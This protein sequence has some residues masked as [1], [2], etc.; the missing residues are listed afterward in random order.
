M[1]IEFDNDLRERLAAFQK[2]MGLSGDGVAGQKTWELLTDQGTAA[3]PLVET[4]VTGEERAAGTAAS[5]SVRPEQAPLRVPAADY[6][7]LTRVLSLAPT[8]EAVKAFLLSDVGLDIDQV[9]AAMDA[10]LP[11]EGAKA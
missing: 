11:A 2:A 8:D 6:P 9:L 4:A 1:A 10:V 7:V 3:E 5:K